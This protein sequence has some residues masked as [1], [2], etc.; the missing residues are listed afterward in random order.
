MHIP[1]ARVD[2]FVQRDFCLVR[3]AFSPSCPSGDTL[4]LAISPATKTLVAGSLKS[5]GATL[6]I[7]CLHLETASGPLEEISLHVVSTCASK[8]FSLE[9]KSWM[10]PIRFAS[11]AENLSPV[12]KYLMIWLAG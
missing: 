6:C 8:S 9:K 3:K 10:R 1:L 4:A 2:H 12:K 5:M 7:N 11:C